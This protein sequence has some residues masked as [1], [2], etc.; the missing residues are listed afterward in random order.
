MADGKRSERIEKI[1]REIQGLKTRWPAHNPPPGLFRQLDELERALEE[2]LK[3]DP[4]A[5]QDGAA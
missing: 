5:P 2:L 1:E 3:E 4:D